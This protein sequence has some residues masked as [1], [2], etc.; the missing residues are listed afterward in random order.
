MSQHA[1]Y[2]AI[3]TGVHAVLPTETSPQLY[4]A[5]LS[6]VC[7]A[8]D[9]EE[10]AQHLLA[11]SQV[12]PRSQRKSKRPARPRRAAKSCAEDRR[13]AFDLVSAAMDEAGHTFVHREATFD[14]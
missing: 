11:F 9:C 3:I 10:R 1:L 6:T 12:A 5:W 14:S 2:L 8:L 4:L 13:A 7:S